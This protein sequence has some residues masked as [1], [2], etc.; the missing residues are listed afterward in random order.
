MGNRHF[1][2]IFF[3]ISLF[4][5]LWSD[6]F[7]DGLDACLHEG[8]TAQAGSSLPGRVLA[9]PLGCLKIKPLFAMLSRN[10]AN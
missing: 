2:F 5:S 6:G 9:T 8:G 1:K 4:F 3:V 7:P 10:N